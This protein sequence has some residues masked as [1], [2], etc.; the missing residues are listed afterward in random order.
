M[1]DDGE[2]RIDSSVV[3][4]LFFESQYGPQVLE[5]LTKVFAVPAQQVAAAIDQLP[6]EYASRERKTLMVRLLERRIQLL[7]ETFDQAS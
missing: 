1:T 6:N 4:S 2:R 7:R 5:S 3:G